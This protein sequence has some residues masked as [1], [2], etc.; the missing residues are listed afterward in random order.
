MVLYVNM[1][2]ASKKNWEF[3]CAVQSLLLLDFTTFKKQIWGFPYNLIF[4]V[5]R[6][7]EKYVCRAPTL[8]S[9]NLKADTICANN[10][11]CP[12]CYGQFQSEVNQ[13]RSSS[14]HML[15]VAKKVHI[16]LSCIASTFILC[17]ITV[18]LYSI[19][20]YMIFVDDRA[21]IDRVDIFG[22]SLHLMNT[23]CT[24]WFTVN[25][26]CALFK[27]CL[28]FLKCLYIN[29]YIPMIGWTC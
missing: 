2:N 15:N 29:E 24:K 19:S 4:V 14:V 20:C 16:L 23:R 18:V 22:K 12:P 28:W 8:S 9:I 26:D 27:I 7:L 6:L 5:F 10:K 1:V 3:S 25:A 13:N 21:D 17:I 11:R